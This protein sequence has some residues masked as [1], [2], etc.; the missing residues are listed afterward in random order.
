MD[1]HNTWIAFD[2]REFHR[3]EERS[4]DERT[5]RSRQP[6]TAARSG[7]ASRGTAW[8]SSQTTCGTSLVS[9]QCGAARDGAEP[10][11]PSPPA[12]IPGSKVQD[13]ESE[14]GQKA[15][16]ANIVKARGPPHAQERWRHAK[17]RT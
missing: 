12:R 13:P 3:T 10:P 17:D 4:P 6:R 5:I 7:R 2:G 9:R 1:V 8:S 11:P 16:R 14:S 15:K